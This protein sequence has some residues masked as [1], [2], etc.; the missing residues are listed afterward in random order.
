MPD[1]AVIWTSP[2]GDTYVTTPGSALL[3][4]S[5]CAPTGEA[6][7]QASQATACCGDRTAKMA[8]RATTRAQNRA[9]YIAAERRKNHQIHERVAV[10]QQSEDQDIAVVVDDEPPPF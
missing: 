5:L 9:R 2:S 10:Q 8:L 1:G 4:P 3:F 7:R 6:P